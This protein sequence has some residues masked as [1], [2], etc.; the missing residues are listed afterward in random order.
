LALTG[1]EAMGSYD[2]HAETVRLRR[3][4]AVVGAS[5][6]DAKASVILGD[7]PTLA[8]DGTVDAL[9]LTAL[10]R[11][12]P[13]DLATAVRTWLIKGVRDGVLRRCRVQL[14]ASATLT[15]P[16]AGRGESPAV[17][18]A[19]APGAFDVACDF[20]G[21]TAHYLPP[22][23]P[24]RRATGSARLTADRFRVD[25]KAGQ[26]GACQVEAGTLTMNLTVKPPT[27]VITADLSGASADVLALVDEP[28]LVLVTPLGIAPKDLGGRS[29]VHAELRLPVKTGLTGREVG[30]QATAALTEA[31]LPPLVAGIGIKDGQLEVRIDGR[32]IE[33][34][35]TTGMT[36][37]TAVAT[38]VT[39]ALT[40]APGTRTQDQQVTFAFDG[41]GLVARG[42][43]S[44]AGTTVTALAVDRL[45]LGRNDL[46][47]TLRR[48]PAGDYEATLTGSS[49]DLE[50][51]LADPRLASA[52]AATLAARYQ[53]SLRVDRVWAS[54]DLE[55]RELRGSVQGDGGRLGTLALTGT[56]APRGDFNV[57]FDGRVE[58]RRIVV[59]SDQAGRL[60]QALSGFDQIVGGRLTL[61]AITDQRGPE[62]FL[63]GTMVMRDFKLVRA[64]ILAK[65][66]AL[67]S[68]AGTAALVQGDGLPVNKARV[69]FRWEAGRLDVHAVRAIGAVGLTA[70]GGF[71]RRAGTS[72]LRGNII[73]AY[74]LNTALGRI[75]LI[76]GL[77]VGGKGEGVFGIAYRVSGMLADP[78]VSVNPLTSV[79]PTLLR[80]WFVDPFV[81]GMA[82]VAPGRRPRAG[83]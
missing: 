66:L 44:L 11:L 82:G 22:L 7:A 1:L 39:M 42:T 64:P 61:D 76:G 63:E 83:R 14:G 20:D 57:T 55:I 3:L 34:K 79:T 9:A 77:L 52:D 18:A 53:L 38:P 56:L 45:R 74:T 59:T 2:P 75:P 25:L 4:A 8:F 13:V 37:L 49:L 48:R 60:L 65:V 73:P 30:L 27:A 43:A 50:A 16:A 70:D 12:W 58:G 67:G 72:D 10:T 71:D 78:A 6:V 41:D 19:A 54:R 15:D 33:V 24:I 35:G 21:V 31:S 51:L 68:L 40:I 80:T 46:A 36:G 23:D 47:G 26:I 62:V 69:P 5:R 17:V 29:R 81:R 32:T 28:P